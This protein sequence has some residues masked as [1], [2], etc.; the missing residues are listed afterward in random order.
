LEYFDSWSSSNPDR[1][2]PAYVC[3]PRVSAVRVE[4]SDWR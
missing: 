1:N 2:Q 3:F 4:R